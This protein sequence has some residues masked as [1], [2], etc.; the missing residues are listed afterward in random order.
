MRRFVFLT[1]LSLMLLPALVWAQNNEP[2]TVV[3]GRHYYVHK[4]KKG[5]T[6]WGLSKIYKV[7]VEELSD[8]NPDAA[9]G[10]SIGEILNI[11]VKEKDSGTFVKV[12]QP[13]P[14]T[15]SAKESVKS[16]LDQKDR[17]EVQK[18]ETIYGISHKYGVT[19]QELVG[20]NPG[21]ESGLRAGQMLVIPSPK[22][23][24]QTGQ[25]EQKTQTK[26]VTDDKKNRHEVQKGETIYGISHK[27]GVTEQEL[28]GMNPGIENGLMAGQ[29][30]VIPS[31]S[32][33]TNETNNNAVRVSTKTAQAT[34][35]ANAKPNEEPDNIY[36]VK[37]G[38]TL[39]C[40]AR[41]FGVD[42]ADIK[43]ANPG[44]TNFPI[45]G[46]PITMPERKIKDS[47]FVH[48]VEE[49]GKTSNFV[50]KW[51]MTVE[52]FTAINSSV[53][54]RV[55]AGQAVLIP[56][57][58]PAEN[59]VANT[60]DTEISVVVKPVA[61]DVVKPDTMQQSDTVI[62]QNSVELIESHM[63]CNQVE[64]TRGATY[65]MAL[66]VPLYLDEIDKIEVRKD[67]SDMARKARP[68][69]FLHY[70]EG[71]MMAVNKLVEED[72]LNLDLQVIDVDEDV[73]KAKIAVNKLKQSPVDVIIGPF[74]SRS[75]SVV[76]DYAK[77]NGVMLVN[78][79]SERHNVVENSPNVVKVKPDW[80]TQTKVLCDFLV[81]NYQDALC[82]VFVPL[83][84]ENDSAV[85]ALANTIKTQ[86]K[87][88]TSD[89]E[90][91]PCN[92]ASFKTLETMAAK[93]QTVVVAVGDKLVFATQML[94]SLNKTANKL[95][96]TLVA[97]HEWNNFDNLLVDNLMRMNAIYLSDYFVDYSDAEVN[98]F[99]A[100]F[101]ALHKYDPDR[102]AFIG[103]DMACYFLNALMLYGPE[104][105]DCLQDYSPKMMHTSF[106]FK[107][108]N[109]KDGVENTFW[110]LYQYDNE[111]TVINI[112]NR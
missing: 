40:V 74:F 6:L 47:F 66:L 31:S 12:V 7:S 42:I 51:D 110:N 85:L 41:K 29:M 71:F 84:E 92:N 45:E 105:C 34:T 3:N 13:L 103:Y 77:Q 32:Q 38:E 52:E 76:N 25:I 15:V 88:D 49:N 69:K 20:M 57:L 43:S 65:R 79:L 33:K 60:K 55:Y 82:T 95:P 30:L 97:M 21:I 46:L 35:V 100:D 99:V 106:N 22:K 11:P 87:N 93:R 10:L 36:K 18:G 58:E 91:L 108:G 14:D 50:E 23:T 63:P 54:R 64:G 39:Y 4:V 78:P 98:N 89:V 112:L 9:S 96:L 1:F 16:S 5:E 107:R 53:G 27:Y 24:E 81:N 111:N 80:S 28:V 72:G 73:E 61:V 94:N 17:H 102:Y 56:M 101:R 90:V 2:I 8:V 83:G 70:Y 19:E 67:K 44:L 62:Q 86:V 104:P 109:A 48:R 37:K 26:P 68:F 59:N 75:F